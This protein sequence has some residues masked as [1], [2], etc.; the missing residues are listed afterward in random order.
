MIHTASPKTL[1]HSS[2]SQPVDKTYGPSELHAIMGPP[3]Q[4]ACYSV[5]STGVEFNTASLRYFVTPQLGVDLNNGYYSFMR[6]Y[7]YTMHQPQRLD[8]VLFACLQSG[9]MDYLSRA[10]V[11]VRRGVLVKCVLNRNLI[12]R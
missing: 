4:I 12:I 6:R 5:T 7:M 10:N 9:A 8:N 1:G 11:V 3:K 2:T